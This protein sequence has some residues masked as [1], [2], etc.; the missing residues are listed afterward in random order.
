[1]TAGIATLS[2][3]ASPI[4]SLAQKNSSSTALLAQNNSSDRVGTLEV[5]AELPIRPA[6]VTVN[7]QGRI[8]ATVHWFDR[9]EPQ[10]IEITGR[11]EYKPYPNARW[12]RGFGQGEDAFDQPLGILVDAKNRLW[13]VDCGVFPTLEDGQPPLSNRSPRLLAFDT[14]TGENVYNLALPKDTCPPGTYPQDLAIDEVNDFAYLADIGGSGKPAIAVVNL[15]NDRV[16][17][18]EAYPSLSAENVDLMVE[19]KQ[20]VFPDATGK[21][22]PAR[23]G[24]NPITL[25]EDN[26]TVFFGAMCGL[27]W[28]SV[29][30]QL[31]RDNADDSTIAAAI[32]RIANK[33]V[34]DGVSTDAEGNHF[35]TNLGENAIDRI[36][37]QGQLT[38][39]VQ[40]D[41]L[42]WADGV[43]FGLDSWLY[44]SVNQLN[45]SPL[46]SG[47]GEQG[48]PPYTIMRVWTGTKGIVGR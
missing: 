42:I 18:F 20:L 15:K 4:K 31:L 40:D 17:R 29:S 38:R 10:V 6:L 43:R 16:R 46:F 22:V 48:K 44:I 3:L 37:A 9:Q 7:R 1:K 24:I 39:L 36:D 34:C 2:S 41:R 5:V 28:Y 33:P 25:S 14:E 12:N 23:I 21:F 27:G 11:K 19:G 30:A 8:F 35:L 32:Q 26:E 13:T 45:R 47:A